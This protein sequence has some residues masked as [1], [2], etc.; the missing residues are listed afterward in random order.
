MNVENLYLFKRCEEV[1]RAG[2]VFSENTLSPHELCLISNLSHMSEVIKKNL[3][4]IFENNGCESNRNILY[5]EQIDLMLHNHFGSGIINKGI[6]DVFSYF[7]I[8]YSLFVSFIMIL[9]SSYVNNEFFYEIGFSYCKE[10]MDEIE[11]SLKINNINSLNSIE[12]NKKIYN[13]GLQWRVSYLRTELA[14]EYAIKEVRESDDF[15]QKLKLENDKLDEIKGILSKLED[16]VAKASLIKDFEEFIQTTNRK[17]KIA[18]T[19]KWGLLVAILIIPLLSF[20]STFL[21]ELNPTAVAMRTLSSVIVAIILGIM[22]RVSIRN[23]DQLE[24]IMHKVGNKTAVI[25]YYNANKEKLD[26]DKKE[27]E[28]KFYDFLFKDI[29]TKEWNSPDV[30]QSII[31]IIKAVKSS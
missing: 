15:K 31:D 18:R 19:I 10:N 14:K 6:N 2:E 4:R 13:E 17:L 23:E 11:D 16:E 3:L 30:G 5:N 20:A 25:Y 9:H 8:Y 21:F 22:L 24:Q 7:D 26:G 29:E 1:I 27:I 28:G 12:N